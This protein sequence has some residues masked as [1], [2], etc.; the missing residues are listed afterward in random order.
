M[1][2]LMDH[3]FIADLLIILKYQGLC[4]AQ[5]IYTTV[6]VRIDI[7]YST[8]MIYYLSLVRRETKVLTSYPRQNLSRSHSGEKIDTLQ[9]RS[10]ER[11][12]LED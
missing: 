8:Y 7:S 9:D 5:G 11:P 3:T 10:M 4:E 2:S 12:G 6:T 1:S